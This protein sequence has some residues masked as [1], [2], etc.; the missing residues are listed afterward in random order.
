MKNKCR[1]I[2]VYIKVFPDSKL[3]RFSTDYKGDGAPFVIAM[4]EVILWEWG[5]AVPAKDERTENLRRMD[6]SVQTSEVEAA[7]FTA[8]MGKK[9]LGVFHQALLKSGALTRH[10]R[11]DPMSGVWEVLP[12]ETYEKHSKETRLSV[13]AQL[14]ESYC[15]RHREANRGG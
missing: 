11:L 14:Q 15:R 7:I 2:V 4:V 6:I 5:K 9:E 8:K 1:D 13:I 3:I 12:Q 10:I